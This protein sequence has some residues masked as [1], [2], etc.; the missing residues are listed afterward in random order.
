[1]DDTTHIATAKYTVG[2]YTF[3]EALPKVGTP[4]DQSIW[5]VY[6]DNKLLSPNSFATVEEAMRYAAR[7]TVN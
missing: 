4:S 6:A 5:F 1:M 7:P 2:R 3:L